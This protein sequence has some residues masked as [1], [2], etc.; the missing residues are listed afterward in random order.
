MLVAA[1]ENMNQFGRVA[2]CGVISEYT[3]PKRHA[4]PNMVN[5]IYK[6]ITIQGFLGGDYMHKLADFISATSDHIR[7]NE[8]YVLEDIS[9]GLESIPLAFEGL[10]AGDNIGKKIV[11]LADI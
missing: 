2:V 9:D 4:G 11:K 6:R 3:D 5:V 1:T 8:M 10:F 7:K